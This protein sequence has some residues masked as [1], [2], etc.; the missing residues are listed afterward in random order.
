[1]PRMQ[2]A[3]LSLSQ[4]AR[5]LF[6]T[7]KIP[8]FSYNVTVEMP[9]IIHLENPTPIPVLIHPRPRWEQTS[10]IVRDIPQQ[11]N[12]RGVFLVSEIITEVKTVGS[13]IA[14]YGVGRKKADLD[15]NAVL[16]T[17]P[18]AILIPCGP[19]E[20]P[21]DLGRTIGLRINR[22]GRMGQKKQSPCEIT[23]T[24]TRLNIKRTYRLHW[25]V[26][27]SIADEKSKFSGSQ[28]IVILTPIRAD[29]ARPHGLRYVEPEIDAAPP[30]FVEAEDSRNVKG[31]EDKTSPKFSEAVRENELSI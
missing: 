30:P 10:G 8:S 16:N 26:K 21:L 18:I 7:S 1:M 28:D 23:P 9:T 25:T 6:H 31:A 27:L 3:S 11:V 29:E 20:P 17:P 14:Y 19:D 15:V 22:N 2:G 4:K 24:S 13:V 12:L 5:R